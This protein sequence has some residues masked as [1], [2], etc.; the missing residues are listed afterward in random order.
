MKSLTVWILLMLMTLFSYLLTQFEIA[1]IY[2]FILFA[3][4]FLL[5]SVY[6]M[7]LKHGHV[8]WRNLL[9]LYLALLAMILLFN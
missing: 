3:F 9:S 2:I 8:F 4:K 5:V 6:F 1:F 7:E